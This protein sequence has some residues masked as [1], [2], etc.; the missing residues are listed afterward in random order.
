MPAMSPQLFFEQNQVAGQSAVVTHGVLPSLGAPASPLLEPAL[1]PLG[2][3]SLPAEPPASVFAPAP[4][5]LEPLEPA[6][7]LAATPASAGR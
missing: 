4:P 3:A 2:P 5:P 6:E 1:P 7:P